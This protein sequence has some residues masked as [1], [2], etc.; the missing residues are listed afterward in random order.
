MASF[1]QPHRARRLGRHVEPVAVVGVGLP[2][3]PA[4]NMMGT[5]G[6]EARADLGRG[7]GMRSYEAGLDQGCVDVAE[8]VDL[9]DLV[10]G[11]HAVLLGE[12][13]SHSHHVHCLVPR[14]QGKHGGNLVMNAPS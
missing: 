3:G 9:E 1:K 10:L 14:N 6:A 7:R 13:F 2:V 8:A 11:V 5:E 4:P 12:A